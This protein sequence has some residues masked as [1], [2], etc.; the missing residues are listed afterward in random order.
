M[1]N[2]Y[3]TYVHVMK[4]RAVINFNEVGTNDTN[5]VSAIIYFTEKRCHK[6]TCLMEVN[7]V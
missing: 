4:I 6:I 1:K 5:T 2:K 7:N 3:N